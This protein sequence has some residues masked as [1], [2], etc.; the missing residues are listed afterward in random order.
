MDFGLT[1]AQIGE[2]RAI[3][4]RQTR[5]EVA[6]VYGSR[7]KGNFTPYSDLDLALEG[8]EIDFQILGRLLLDFDDSRLPV[9]VDMQ[10]LAAIKSAELLGHIERVGKV[11]YR[12]QEP[13]S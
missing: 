1:E 10:R 7:A 13:R 6:W 8:N 12:R 2:V 3:L 5:V 11:I 9:R 4:G